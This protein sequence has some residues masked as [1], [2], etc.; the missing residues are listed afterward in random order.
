MK[1]LKHSFIAQ[2]TCRITEQGGRKTPAKSGYKPQV[3]F[4]FTEMQTS[5]Q[6]IFLDKEIVYPGDTVKEEIT[7]LTPDTLKGKIKVGMTYEFQEGATDIGTGKI[8]E[9]LADYL[10]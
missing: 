2:L 1:H 6:K 8:L 10:N 4:E 3:A 7:D 5:G 9:I